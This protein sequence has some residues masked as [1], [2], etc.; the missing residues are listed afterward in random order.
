MVRNKRVGAKAS[1][2]AAAAA[3]LLSAC[4]GAGVDAEASAAP[5]EFTSFSNGW[6]CIQNLFRRDDLVFIQ[7]LGRPEHG[8]T[9]N[10][11]DELNYWRKGPRDEIAFT[12]LQYEL[13]IRPEELMQ[14][15][16]KLVPIGY[17]NHVGNDFTAEYLRFTHLMPEE[18]PLAAIR[19]DPNDHL[20]Q[21]LAMSEEAEE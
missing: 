13:I 8:Y 10:E 21:I 19:A 20:D 5:S 4:G 16:C 2:L 12:P 1:V 9:L 11:R 7:I 18:D 3:L 15:L 6:F 14:D 17:D